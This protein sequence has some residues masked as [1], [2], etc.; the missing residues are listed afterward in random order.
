MSEAAINVKTGMQLDPK[1]LD[2]LQ[3]PVLQAIPDLVH[4]NVW[5]LKAVVG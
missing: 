1:L 3:M 2:D 4:V 5:K